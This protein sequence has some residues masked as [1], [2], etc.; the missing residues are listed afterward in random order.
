MKFFDYYFQVKKVIKSASEKN[1]ISIVKS[2]LNNI[3]SNYLP[4]Y[5]LNKSYTA[6]QLGFIND[7]YNLDG[8]EWG[9][10]VN[11]M[12]VG[13]DKDSKVVDK[14][15]SDVIIVF[16][17]CTNG[18]IL[19]ISIPRD[20]LVVVN[21][22]RWAGSYDKIGHSL[23]WG[24]M[25]NLKKNVEDLLGSP[26]YK[27]AIV[28]NFTNFEAF[29][30][31]IGG[32]KIDKNLGGKLGVQWIRNRNFK[33]GDIERCKRQQVFIKSAVIKLWKMSNKGNYIYSSFF[34]DMFK[35]I[36]YSDITKDDF[37]KIVYLLRKNKFNPD[38][39]FLTGLLPGSFDRYDS[40]LLKRNN[41]VCW[42]LDEDFMKNLRFL[43]YS[44]NDSYKII[45]SN[46]ASFNDFV[47]E[48]ITQIKSRVFKK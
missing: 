14:A 27:V 16:R 28:D 5:D 19:S 9:E 40:K 33:D 22:D 39:D 37:L 24:G 47:K 21:D 30:A 48:D 31:I 34:Y 20:T 36:I 41:L 4:A 3:E 35:E 1:N 18:K 11:F 10:G 46:K 12:L 6:S 13:S 15:R 44:N 29:L 32:L 2:D 7:L 25:D 26:I 42:K 23:Y 38:K 43:L 17:I 45:M 8:S